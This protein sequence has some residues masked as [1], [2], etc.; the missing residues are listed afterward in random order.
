MPKD[1]TYLKNGT[2][3]MVCDGCDTI[4]KIVNQKARQV[5]SAIIEGQ[6]A[7]AGSTLAFNED[8]RAIQN[9]ESLKADVDLMVDNLVTLIKG[10]KHME[11][12]ADQLDHAGVTGYYA[13]PATVPMGDE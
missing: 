11:V 12:D 4:M 13:L 1:I 6:S 5:Q 2:G 7:G 9:L 3:L 8:K 10:V